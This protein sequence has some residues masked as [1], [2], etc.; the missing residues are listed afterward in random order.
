MARLVAAGTR[1][2]GVG[3]VGL[4]TSGLSTVGLARIRRGRKVQGLALLAASG[5]LALL[6][7]ERGDAGEQ[8]SPRK[9]AA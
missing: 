7:Q 6:R 4:L 1:V 2:T 9:D 8:S 3:R 5:V